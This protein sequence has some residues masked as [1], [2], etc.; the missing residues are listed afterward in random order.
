MKRLFFITALILFASYALSV[1]AANQPT[2]GTNLSGN[3]ATPHPLL[4]QVNLAMKQQWQKIMADQKSGKL[5][6]DQSKAL[7][8]KLKDIHTQE[9][10]FFKNDPNHEL[11]SDQAAQLNQQLQTTAQSIP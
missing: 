3:S 9:V 11:T 8:E 1:K 10:G 7:R 6:L 2:P 5:T 4:R